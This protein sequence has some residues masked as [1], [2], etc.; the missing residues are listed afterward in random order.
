VAYLL[1]VNVLIARTDPR[2]KSHAAVRA[3]LAAAGS[4]K[5]LFCPLVENGFLRI[6]GHPAYPGGPGSPGRAAVDLHHMRALPNAA[7]VA[8]DVSIDDT[9]L[10]PSTADITPR[11]LTD[12]YLLGLAV[13]KGARFATL[14]G[15]IPEGAVRGGQNA[16]TVIPQE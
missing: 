4:E 7:F 5:L 13:S 3:W 14:D 8:D 2:H 6:Y 9:A 12:V 16:L 1:D 15:G 11:Q 10:F